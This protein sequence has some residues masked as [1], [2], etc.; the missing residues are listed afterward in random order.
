MARVLYYDVLNY[1]PEHLEFMAKQFDLLRLPSPDHDS[2]DVLATVDGIFAPLKYY[3]GKDKIDAC[4]KLRVIASSTTGAPHIDVEYAES[5][6]V[7]VVWLEHETE[8]LTT[9]TPVSELTWGLL[10]GLTRRIPWSFA[11]V[12]GGK[13]HRWD[14]PSPR[15]LSRMELGI[16]GLGRLGIMVA[17]QGKAFG[18]RVRYYDPYVDEPDEPGIERVS[19]LKT[20]VSNS[21]VVS[22]HTHLNEKTQGMVDAALFA[23]FRK[24]SYLVN[25][26]RGAIV[27]THALLEALDN[28]TLAG[29]ATDVL[30]DEFERSF[31]GDVS[32][33]PL[34]LYANEH[35]NLLI[36]PHIGGSTVDAWRETQ[37]HTIGMMIKV[38]DDEQ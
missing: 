8:F 22:L 14:W 25:T 28:G 21:D 3:C 5:K 26:A 29:A 24:G 27:D 12:R 20:L 31:A 4:P 30:D 18:M 2:T 23:E 36:T 15:M 11:A 35:D 33:H 10:I 17:R 9:I 7:K 32:V 1:R 16:V 6:G 13:W 37:E 19:D 38:L 34:V